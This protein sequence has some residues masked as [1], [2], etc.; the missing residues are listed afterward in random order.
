MVKF[1]D[2]G[3]VS[4]DSL[5]KQSE[6]LTDKYLFIKF[7][8]KKGFCQDYIIIEK[9]YDISIYSDI[10]YVFD[11]DSLEGRVPLDDIGFILCYASG[12]D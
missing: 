1:A 6:D 9:E 4:F 3:E 7:K 10:L 2:L 5:K 12:D 11:Y 8:N